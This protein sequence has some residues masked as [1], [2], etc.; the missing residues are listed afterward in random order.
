MRTQFFPQLLTQ[1][2]PLAIA[3]HC[4][5]TAFSIRLHCPRLAPVSFFLCLVRSLMLQKLRVIIGT[6]STSCLDVIP[7]EYLVW[8]F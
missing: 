2:G 7:K 6:L 1:N 8:G 5:Q 4:L 3:L